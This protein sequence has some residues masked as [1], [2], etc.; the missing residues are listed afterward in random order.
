M[1]SELESNQTG[2][3]RQL[4]NTDARPYLVFWEATRACALACRHC[5]AT[6]QPRPHPC[7]LNAIEA[8]AFIRQVARAE[9]A[10]FVITGGDPMCRP[11]IHELISFADG[12][13]IPISLSPSATPRLLREDFKHLRRLGVQRMSLSI[14]GPD[15]ASHD[16]F[17]GVR[18]AWQWTIEAVR[19]CQEAGIGLQINT[20]ITRDNIGRFEDFSMAVSSLAPEMWSIFLLVPVGRGVTEH[21][22]SAIETEAFFNK[23]YSFSL[24]APFAIKTTEGMHYRRVVAQ[25]RRAGELPPKMAPKSQSST[26]PGRIPAP[27]GTND[28]KGIVF[29]SHIG[30]I[31]PS[32]F[33][34]VACGNVKSHELIDV[35]RNH[36]V[37][38]RLRDPGQLEGK[39]GSCEY[40]RLCGG[41]RARAYATSKRYM[42]E[43]PLCIY[44]PAMSI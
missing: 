23:L 1:I 26:L 12:L 18:G 4:W 35:Y 21:L 31:C 9:P 37:F 3:G 5:R 40:N 11:D 22:P 13:G 38:K 42:G 33:F 17:R 29:V 19:R 30:E 14:D 44:Q 25:R 39:C 27:V 36:P 6:A 24:Q 28:G 8:L 32:G 34:P 15:E 16:S 7:Q 20:T 10:H 43:E 41:S 2:N